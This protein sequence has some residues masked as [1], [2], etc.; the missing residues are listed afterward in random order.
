M[1]WITLMRMPEAPR[2]WEF[3]RSNI[4]ARTSSP[5]IRLPVPT[6][7][8]QGMLFCSSMACSFEMVFQA[9]APKPLVTP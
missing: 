8:N 3:M 6:L 7:W 2:R 9:M 1:R 5:G 4:A